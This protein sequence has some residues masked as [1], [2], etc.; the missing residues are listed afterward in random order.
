[1]FLYVKQIKMFKKKINFTFK[2]NIYIG[3]KVLRL[4]GYLDSGNVLS[5]KNK[6]V[7]LT[8]IDNNFR[9]KKI[10][11]PYIVIGG[12]GLLDYTYIY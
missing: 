8:N 6:P 7:I 4:N 1:M 5:Y 2:T 9:N 11:I 12:T 3:R 10:Y